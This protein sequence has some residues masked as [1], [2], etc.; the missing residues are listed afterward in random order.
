MKNLNRRAFLGT[1]LSGLAALPFLSNVLS[2]SVHAGGSDA[3]PRRL[4]VFYTPNEPIASEHWKPAGISDGDALTELPPVMASLEPHMQNLLMV[5]DLAMHTQAEET[6]GAGHV[7]LGHMLTGRLV[8]PYGTNAADYWGSGISVDQ[9][10]ADALGVNALTLGVL[11]GGANGNSRMSYRGANQP[12]H[13]MARPDDVFD[14]LFA[15]FELPPSEL[16]ALRGRRLSVL[17]RA[18]GDLRTLSDRLPRE[19][20]DKL[21]VHLS[22]VRDLET[23]LEADTQLECT[24][25]D[26]PASADYTANA[27]LPVTTQRQIDIM[28]QALACGITDVA[29]LQVGTTGAGAITPLW[30]DVG[31]DI[32]QDCHT[33]AHTWNDDAQQRQRRISLEAFFYSQFAYLLDQLAAIPEGA[34][35]MLDNTLVL[36]TKHLGWGHRAEEMMFMLAGGVDSPLQPGRYIERPNAPHNQLLASVC[37]LMGTGDETFGDPAFGSGLLDL[38]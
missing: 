20:A 2:R 24:L 34:G 36:W 1:G 29:S 35:S 38:G 9:H 27:M 19:A 13:P 37:D 12:V 23:K 6:H 5:G 7:T 25:P 14:S 10:I 30:P 3:A 16:A 31:L 33:L 8:S 32:N 21:D 15:D 18:A 11:S 17:D 4:I 28:V 26:A 22:L